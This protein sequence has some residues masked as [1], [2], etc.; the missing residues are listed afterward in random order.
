MYQITDVPLTIDWN[1]LF[2]SNMEKIARIYSW[3]KTHQSIIE[4]PSLCHSVTHAGHAAQH[5]AQIKNGRT[6]HRVNN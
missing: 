4:N 3:K 1:V 6:A 2:D 5:K